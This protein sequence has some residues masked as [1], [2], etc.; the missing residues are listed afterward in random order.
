MVVVDNIGLSKVTSEL[1]EMIKPE[2]EKVKRLGGLYVIGTSRHESRRIDNQLRGRSGRQGDPGGT[3]FFLSMEDDIFMT[4]GGMRFVSIQFNSTQPMYIANI[5]RYNLGDKMGEVLEKFRVAEDMPIENDLV[6]QALDKV[7]EKVEAYF[8]SNRRQVF[9]LDE[10]M[11]E[12]RAAV[13]RDRQK[14]LNAKDS[15]IIDVFSDYCA[16][17]MDEIY[18]VGHMH[19]QTISLHVLIVPIMRCSSFFN[20][21]IV[22]R[23]RRL[24]IRKVLM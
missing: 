15:E 19:N 16:K 17:T 1:E 11:S 12:Q 7:Q 20:S 6:M 18:K 10:V 2:R 24:K 3:R 21:F 23:H 9:K 4:F 14:F 22:Y 8:A 13:Y 5:L